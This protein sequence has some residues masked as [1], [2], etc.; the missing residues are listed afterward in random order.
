MA[1]SVKRSKRA[2]L[3]APRLYISTKNYFFRPCVSERE[4]TCV[5]DQKNLAQVV[6]TEIV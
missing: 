2:D 5:P 1:S 6:I 3:P 4:S